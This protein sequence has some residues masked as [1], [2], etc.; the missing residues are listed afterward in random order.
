MLFPLCDDILRGVGNLLDGSNLHTFSH[1]STQFHNGVW[2]PLAGQHLHIFVN[3]AN[4]DRIIEV[5]TSGNNT[6]DHASFEIRVFDPVVQARF[7]DLCL[8]VRKLKINFR[9]KSINPNIP[10]EEIS[11]DRRFPDVVA[12]ALECLGRSP[13]LASLY[14]DFHTS[15]DSGSVSHHNQDGLWVHPSIYG[16]VPRVEIGVRAFLALAKLKDAKNLRRLYI[17]LTANRVRS[18]HVSMLAELYT[19]TTIHTLSLKL[20][21]NPHIGFLGVFPLTRLKKAHT[22]KSLHLGLFDIMTEFAHVLMKTD[23]R[24]DDLWL[25]VRD[26]PSLEKLYLEL[27]YSRGKPF[28][29]GLLNEENLN[30]PIVKLILRYGTVIPD[31]AGTCTTAGIGCDHVVKSRYNPYKT[32]ADF[33][34]GFT[35]WND[36]P[37]VV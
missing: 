30:V 3:A 22:L 8:H 24:T 1:L 11:P 36:G 34:R 16:R 20:N 27:E 31:F 25:A 6:L 23:P 26:N 9:A 5:I 14:L 4:I 10:W 28:R 18:V 12:R 29:G 33:L 37:L 35:Q 19:S 13:L 15:E 32:E 7:E 21:N 2:H 17:D